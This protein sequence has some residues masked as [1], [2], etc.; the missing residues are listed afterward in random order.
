MPP[1]VPWTAHTDAVF[2]LY[3]LETTAEDV[4]DPIGR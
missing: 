2:A 4:S 1:L 3:N